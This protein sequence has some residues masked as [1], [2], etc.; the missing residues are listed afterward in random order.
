MA[1][2]DISRRKLLQGV[3]ATMVASALPPG[4]LAQRRGPETR[5]VPSTGERLP[6]VGLGTWITF[7]V[8]NDPV[9]LEECTEVMRAFFSAGGRLI[10]SSP[11]YGSSQDTIGHGLD[12]LAAHDDVYAADKIWT[13]SPGSGPEQVEESREKWGVPRF[14][15]LQVHNLVAWE[16]NLD[17][18]L[19]MKEAGEL[20]HV[21]ITTSHGRRH[22][23]I[24]RIMREKPLDFIQI[25]YNVLDREVEQRLLPLARE[26]GIG[27][28]VNRPFQ[29]GRLIERLEGKPLPEW[30]NEI[31]A[32]SWA[33]LLLKFI[34]SH[35]DVSCAIPA[36]TRVDHL[37][38]N[39]AAGH[40]PLPDDTLR[41][42]MAD[43]VREL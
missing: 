15:L 10:D 40:S 3:M 11:M 41:Q 16:E 4:A 18:L 19:E 22:D 7:N 31:E 8:G 43:Y 29:Q 36:T 25:T 6:L 24:E 13:S 5:E 14:D 39:M 21:G 37:R 9:L 33:Q 2:H 26:K 20:R 27:V 32:D 42:R 28:I 17:T 12:E 34:I 1:D 35:P 38:E 30:A 23:A